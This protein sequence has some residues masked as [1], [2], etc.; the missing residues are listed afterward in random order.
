MWPVASATL[1]PAASPRCYDAATFAKPV[2]TS[3]I[4]L[5]FPK[6]AVKQSN[7]AITHK[8]KYTLYGVI[9]YYTVKALYRRSRLDF[10]F[11]QPMAMA[12]GSRPG[13]SFF[14]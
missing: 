14:G 12:V 1:V 2:R 5:G 13:C 11:S 9:L 7:S 4:A 8:K 10:R 6:L 3:D